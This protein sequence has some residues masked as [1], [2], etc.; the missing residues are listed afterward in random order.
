MGALTVG[1][2]VQTRNRSG[3][4]RGSAVVANAVVVK[5]GSLICATSSSEAILC[6]DLGAAGYFVGISLN[7]VTGDGTKTVEYEYNLEVLLDCEAGVTYA[8]IN[9]TVYAMTDAGVTNAST[10]GPAVGVLKELQTS[11]RAWVLLCGATL[12]ANT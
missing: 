3:V 4:K 5:K 1:I 12:A 6:A 2:N 10:V 11:S 9:K 7:D 8:L